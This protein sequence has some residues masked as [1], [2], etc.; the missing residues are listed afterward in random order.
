MKK[1][2]I[3]P[4]LLNREFPYKND[5]FKVRDDKIL[6][7]MYVDDKK[8]TSEKNYFIVDS[9]D[10]VVIIAKKDD[11]VLVVNQFRYPTES[12][13]NE[14]VAGMVD[15]KEDVE[16]AAKR[17]LE[18]EAGIKV[19]SIKKLGEF[20]PTVG[21]GSNKAH[22]FYTDEFEEKEKEL[23]EYEQF[24]NLTTSWVSIE[25]FNKMIVDGKIKDAVTLSTWVLF[26]KKVS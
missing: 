17:E 4:K 21:H 2:I 6:C 11:K 23:E 12:F 25:K 24:M 14:F 3:K 16:K 5:Y 19:K 15:D 9:P 7:K 22:I 20:Y 1:S 26:E 8:K 13:C 10:F 18:E